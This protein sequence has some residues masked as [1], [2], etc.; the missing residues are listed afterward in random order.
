[1]FRIAA[2]MLLHNRARFAST[3]AGMSLAF[4]ITVAQIGLL[5]GWCNTTS[6]V[7][8]NA[9]VDLWV[10]ARETVAFDYGIAIP[11]HRVQQVRSV[12]GVEWAEALLMS[13]VFWRRPDGRSMSIEMVGLDD[14]LIGGPWQMTEGEV[15]DVHRP[16]A[17]IIDD[18]YC[19]ALG[20]AG[21]GDEVEILGSKAV[22]R[23]VSHGV[24]TFTAAPFVFT[25]IETAYKYEPY[26]RRDQVTYV[27]VRCQAG[28]D[29]QRVRAEILRAVPAVDVLTTREFAGR[30][31]RF[32]MLETGAGITVVITAVLGL[33]VGTMINSQ[34]LFAITNDHRKDYATLLAV[35]F[36]RLWLAGAV[37]LQSALLGVLSTLG[38][39][40][41][42]AVAAHYLSQTPVPLE[43]TARVFVG[44]ALA[45]FGC[46]LAA[47]LLSVRSVLR[48][49]PVSVF[50]A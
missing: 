44:T 36:G 28:D 27:L 2:S 45:A 14:G 1:M 41:L 23:G 43:L 13:W 30:T 38:G 40:V 10:M 22:I 4:F 25:S 32:W 37:V 39:S 49:D 21:V 47:A 50:Q 24:R 26:Y 35:G 8:R 33:M 5:V 16:D 46:S 12:E 42:F 31:I 20:V 34:T 19:S 29:P 48:I 6:A 15:A 17:V 18:L 3:V 7:V 11:R 9:G